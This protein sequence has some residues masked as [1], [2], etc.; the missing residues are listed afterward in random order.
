VLSVSRYERLVELLPELEHEP[1]LFQ[2]RQLVRD[3]VCYYLI[4]N[5]LFAVINRFGLDGIVDEELLLAFVHDRLVELRSEVGDLGTEFVDLL[6][7]HEVLPYKGNLLTRIEDRDELQSEN[8]LG[9][10]TL[11]DN[12]LLDVQQP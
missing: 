10:Y 6:L 3:A 12:P 11:V 7:E 4:F 8:Q 1:Q 9:V 5:Q 2:S